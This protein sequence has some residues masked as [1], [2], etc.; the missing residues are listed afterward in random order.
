MK[1]AARNL[2]LLI[3]TL[4]AGCHSGAPRVDCDTRLTAINVAAPV[5]DEPE[6]RP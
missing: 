2:A 6:R 5:S 4:L 1:T 3:V